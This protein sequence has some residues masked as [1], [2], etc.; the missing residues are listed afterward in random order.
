[1][2]RTFSQVDR[3]QRVAREA[4][5]QAERWDVPI[6][7]E[8]RAYEAA[9]ADCPDRPIRLI[10]T[11]R[12]GGLSLNATPLPNADSPGLVLAVGPEGGWTPEEVQQALE[13]GFLT[14][15]LG[16]VI[17]RAETATL[18]A[19]SILQSRMGTLG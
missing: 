5:Q 13:E 4:A 2:G 14:V 19:L 3:W 12:T 10:L 18:A 15:T 16:K 9:L 6:I 8:P 7:L 1:P 17:L 11:E